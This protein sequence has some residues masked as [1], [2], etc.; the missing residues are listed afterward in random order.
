MMINK[1][2]N[3][4]FNL[5][6]KDEKTKIKGINKLIK[7]F[8]EKIRTMECEDDY[9]FVIVYGYKITESMVKL[10]LEKEGYIEDYKKSKTLRYAIY[11][12]NN[13]IFPPNVRKFLMIMV[14]YRNEVVHGAKPD[15]KLTKTY[16]ETFNLFLLWFNEFYSTRYHIENPF[17]TFYLS[18]IIS[19]LPP[20]KEEVNIDK[21]KVFSNEITID[22]PKEKYCAYKRYDILTKEKTIDEIT[23]AKKLKNESQKLQKRIN[24]LNKEYAKLE[25]ERLRLDNETEQ[26]N[27]KISAL[28]THSSQLPLNDFKN[29]IEKANKLQEKKIKEKSLTQEI[30]KL[31]KNIYKSNFNAQK[32]SGVGIIKTEAQNKK[33][34]EKEEQLHDLKIEITQLEKTVKEEQIELACFPD[35][36][37][38]KLE[39]DNLISMKDKLDSETKKIDEEKKEIIDD[40]RKLEKRIN[41]LKNKNMVKSHELIYPVLNKKPLIDH[42]PK[43]H[44]NFNDD[45]NL[46]NLNC[47]SPINPE[48]QNIQHINQKDLKYLTRL[49][50]HQVE[51]AFEEKYNRL[52]QE[53]RENTRITEET[54]EI[55][56]NIEKKLDELIKNMRNIMDTLQSFSSRQ[57]EN[58]SS[59]EEIENILKSFTDEYIRTITEY[60]EE[61]SSNDEYNKERR[62]LEISLGENAWNKMAEK[63]QNF[64]I[65]SKVMYNDFLMI[66]DMVDYSGICILVSKALEE[67]IFRR[68]F[69][70]FIEYLSEKY[71]NDYSKYHT[72][73]TYNRINTLYENQFTMGNIAYVFCYKE[74]KYDTDAEKKNNE[75]VLM[76]YCEERIFLNKNK[77]EIK[78]LLNEYANNIEKIREDFRNPSAHRNKIQRI[79]AEECFNLV[80]DIEK[81][82]KRM[83]DSFNE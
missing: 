23:K 7:S 55:S 49:I 5:S 52:L 41:S 2:N 44:F 35:Y 19:S 17:R 71:G 76:D 26:I 27:K 15:Y 78:K 70:D 81:L 58:A 72:A 22:S 63:S 56:R 64:L 75:K 25:N 74:S 16:L 24:K 60:W 1:N 43:N 9:V 62:K 46:R 45:S 31:N 6:K 77:N 83:L 33:L 28:R 14:K 36:E 37:K 68:F 39:T 10:Y 3:N 42:Y 30:E 38:I 80:L 61:K 13:G 34:L 57:L 29:S 67:E 18:S 48:I 51:E 32:K 12:K 47:R 20:S 4:Q 69:T 50:T 54:R 66:N 53:I 8:E 21:E 73:L 40:A 82:L 11:A 79:N 65:T 59:E